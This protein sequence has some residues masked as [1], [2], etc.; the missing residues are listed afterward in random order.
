MMRGVGRTMAV[1]DCFSEDRP[2]L[3]LQ[4][5]ANCVGLPKST[6]FRLVQS[7]VQAGYLVRQDNQAYCL[8]PKFL[9]LARL[10]GVSH[11][12]RGLA[13]EVMEQAAMAS[14]EAVILNAVRGRERVCLE[15]IDTSSSLDSIA[16]PG[17][18][19]PLV[20]GATAKVLLAFLP[21]SDLKEAVG[22]ASM[23]SGQPCS[24]LLS[25][26]ERVRSAGYAVTHGERVV[27][28]SAVAAPV[29]DSDDVRYCIA[30]AGPTERMT[31]RL[32]EHIR[33]ATRAGE[34]VSRRLGARASHAAAV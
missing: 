13:R 30:I 21:G 34:E 22:Y 14:G 12:V 32:S 33:I 25:E 18:H 2:S 11:D 3:N 8:S 9:R 29:R 1:F 7:L 24:Q 31:P 4:S 23:V 6:A 16:K 19:I 10:V 5:I 27:G 17:E 28:M 26:L 15:V 20:E